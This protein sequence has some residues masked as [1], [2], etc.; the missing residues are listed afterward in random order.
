MDSAQAT[1]QST[2]DDMPELTPENYVNRELA[3]L[4]FNHRVLAQAKDENLP[5]LD[6]IKFLA[7]FSNNL[8]EFFMVRVAY[9]HSKLRRGSSTR[10]DGIAPSQLLDQVRRRVS[11]QVTEQRRILRDVLD[12]LAEA[13]VRIARFADLT[14]AQREAVR[15]FFHRD[16][17]PVLTP[18]AVDRARPF[19]FISNLSLNLAVWLRRPHQ[20]DAEREFVRLKI[21]EGVPRLVNLQDVLTRIGSRESVRDTFVWVEDVIASNLDM[22]FPGME[23]I[24]AT[25]FRI[26]RNADVDYEYEKDD[27]D[28]ELSDIIEEGLSIRRFG[29]V[30]RLSVPNTISDLTLN[31]LVRQLEIQLERDVYKIDGALGMSSLFQ[32]V[33]ID[34]PD[35]RQPSHTPHPIEFPARNIFDAIRR[36]DIL[37]HHP[38]D[39]FDPV[40]EFFKSAA[41]DP[42]VLAI[43]ATLYRTGSHS[44]V[45]KA[46]MEA[47]DNDK[48]V[49]VLL[50]LKARFDE[51]NNLGWAKEL[52]KRGVHVTYGVEELPY[53]THAKIAMVVRREPDGVRRYVHLGT[54]NYNASTARLYT[55]LGLM[56][57]HPEVGE[58]A[59][60]LFN[61]LTGF[62]PATAYD[63]LLVAPEYLRDDL[64]R[65]IDGEIAAAREGKEARLMFK[66]NQLE[67]DVLIR[68]LYQASQAGV[69]IDLSVR[70]LCC[71]VPGIPGLS[72]NIRVTS[73]VGRFL[74]HSRIYYF[75]NAPP[76][77][78]LYSGSAD[79]MR[80]NL[81]N[82]VEVVWPVLDQRLQLR[83]L[84]VLK[85]GLA[86]NQQAWELQRDGSY[87]LVSPQPGEAPVESQTIFMAD[88]FGRHY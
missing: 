84:S 67:E 45:V 22:L 27:P 34:R 71:L 61:R 25:P 74:E 66:M 63:R 85:T 59:T 38:Y 44:P 76:D 83:V 26:T 68:K 50:E 19:P 17:Y 14:P 7:I 69:K 8:D 28:A 6:R 39:S 37:L 29:H 64:V 49:A 51:E 88:S 82:R 11:E 36:G 33:G 53:K 77:R 47:R 57:C 56:T 40:V 70:G 80:R 3:W 43:K 60:R 13:G 75:H 18:L 81:Y 23:I 42:Q 30:V 52:D 73:V 32:L 54:G 41:T 58:D 16:I 35:L 10:P 21:P 46:L 5:L 87:T 86:D 24:E 1:E 48:Q 72:D 55:D 15:A 12:K 2:F 62:A 4:E 20:T 78:R 9:V 31:Q 79:L 65:L